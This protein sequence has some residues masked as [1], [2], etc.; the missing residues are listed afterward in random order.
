MAERPAISTAR[1]LAT[2]LEALGERPRQAITWLSLAIR[3]RP[4]DAELRRR[5]GNVHAAKGDIADAEA[6]FLAALA[7]Q[8]D[9]GPA[10]LA[11]SGLYLSLGRSAEGGPLMEARAA[12]HPDVVPAVNVDFPQ[13]RGEPLAGR[14]I[15]VCVEQGLGDQIQMSR[16]VNSL[17]AQGA[18]QVTLACRPTLAPLFGTLTGADRVVPIGNSQSVEIPRHDYWSRYFSLPRALGVTLETL[19]AAPYLAAPDDRRAKW[20][21]WA[22]AGAK[23]VG[24][25]WQASPTGYNAAAKRLTPHDAQ[26]LIDRGAVSLHPEDTGAAD[27]ADTAAMVEQ[28]DL[29]ISI[30]TSVAHLAGAMGKPCKTLIPF[31]NADWRW[32]RNRSDS[33]WYPNMRL[34]RQAAPA[35]W[36]GVI[37]QVLA[38]WPA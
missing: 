14:A 38:D 36:S 24:V 34:Y 10:Q 22:A 17:K 15:L 7:I 18:A 28:L 26:R 37:D 16:F 19:P 9:Y 30:D 20:A 4:E 13:W 12:L 1:N 29:V 6:D 2:A 31:L 23:R 27:F 33:P 32:L 5:R 25:C 21:G 3:H 8:P 35:D 11:L